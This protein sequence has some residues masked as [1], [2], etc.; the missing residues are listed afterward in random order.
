MSQESLVSPIAYRTIGVMGGMGALATVDFLH[1]LVAA[2]PASCDQEHIPMLVRFCPEVP[3]RA[4]ALLGRGP[5]PEPALVAAALG[6]ER[7]GAQCLVIT[8]NTAHAWHD[9]IA[10]AISIPILHIADAAMKA[11]SLLGASDAV[12]LLATT[13]T[14]QS[15][16]YQSRRS[17]V[18]SWITSSQ[19]EQELWVMPGIR[20]IKAGRLD[21]GTRLHQ[22][23]AKALV[24]R[25]ATS[26]IMGCTEIPIALAGREVGVP[27]VDSTLAL[28]HACIAWSGVTMNP[29]P[30]P[31]QDSLVLPRSNIANV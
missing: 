3:D 10:Q 8:C 31:A 2:T 6:L 22:M 29:P 12:G 18:A 14:I 5:S 20:A 11:V 4:Q 26:I 28:A 21:E 30:Q 16:I 19:D 24:D 9:A 17:D 15:R 13:G 1:K 25:G 23:A 7:A 27:L